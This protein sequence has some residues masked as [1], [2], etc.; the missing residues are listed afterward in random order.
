MLHA[1]GSLW[2]G[3]A[4]LKGPRFPEEE[5]AILTFLLQCIS[6]FGL[7]Q[8][9]VYVETQ[10]LIVVHNVHISAYDADWV[11]GS[12]LL[13]KIQHQL[14]CLCDIELQVISST[15]LH[16]V[17]HYTFVLRPLTSPNTA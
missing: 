8:L 4:D 7:F 11:W 10:I 6:V 13:P 17:A 15:Q 5:Q 14:F 9:D 12:H 16:K 2:K 1:G 3:S